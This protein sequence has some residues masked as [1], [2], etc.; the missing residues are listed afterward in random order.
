ME[1]DLTL[2]WSRVVVY[3]KHTPLKLVSNDLVCKVF[4][5]ASASASA[6]TFLW[7]GGLWFLQLI[8]II[9]LFESIN[10]R[11]KLWFVRTLRYVFIILA[12]AFRYVLQ[13]LFVSISNCVKYSIHSTCWQSSVV[14]LVIINIQYIAQAF[15][16][17]SK[18]NEHS[19]YSSIVIGS[20]KSLVIRNSL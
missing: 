13:K 7:S 2:Q 11:H 9:V 20:E 17:P 18:R 15:P 14:Y 3:T 5:V 10:M 19:E 4:C 8:S 16:N 1:A 12:P 6:S